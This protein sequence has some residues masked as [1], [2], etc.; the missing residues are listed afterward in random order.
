MS[1]DVAGEFDDGQL[2]A[3]ADAEVRHLVLAGIADGGDL[4]FGTAPAETAGDQ[5]GIDTLEHAA[6][7]LLDVFRI[8][9]DDID[10]AARVDA[11]VLERLD[12][13][14]VGFGQVDVLADEGDLHR[15]L[16]MFE[17]V[18]QAFPHRQV[19]RLGQDAQLV[20][21]DLVDHLLVQHRRDLV[22]GIG[23]QAFDDGFRHHV[24]E[25]RDLAPLL[26]R[27]RAVGAA[28]QDVRLDTD[29]AQFLDRVLGRL[30]LQF[31]G[32]RDVG[33]QGQVHVADVVAA[34]LDAHLADRLEEGQRLDV[35]DRAADLDDGDVGPFGAG[36]DLALI[37]S[38]MCGMTC[39]VLPRYSP[40]RSFLI[41]ESYT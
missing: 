26:D 41:T 17:R 39:T 19:G 13:R 34:L 14:L 11:G 7:L 18:D 24:A 31:A 36:L 8:D 35:A 29:F 12:Q 40:R 3:E 30:G 16:G 27:D 9:I 2:H 10:L 33:Q 37:S 4:A 1:G 22:D 23:I 38:V 5:D 15:M 21:D 28:Q 25:Q 32:G 6:A 20:A